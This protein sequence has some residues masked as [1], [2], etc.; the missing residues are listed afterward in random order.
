MF[1]AAV[2]PV[3]ALESGVAL[4]RRLARFA[5][6]NLTG[7]PLALLSGPGYKFIA[8]FAPANLITIVATVSS[9]VL[10]GFLTARLVNLY[11]IESAI[12]TGT[13]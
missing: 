10:T 5:R 13:R 2:A 9:M 7:G 6:R 11:P 3:C 4:P 1:S 12:V 8:G